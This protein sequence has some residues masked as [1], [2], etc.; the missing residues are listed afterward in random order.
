M[1]KIEFRRGVTVQRNTPF[2]ANVVTPRT[3]PFDAV[4][5]APRLPLFKQEFPEIDLRLV[6]NIWAETTNLDGVDVEV[7][8]GRVTWTDAQFEKLSDESIVPICAASERSKIKGTKDVAHGP[9]IPFPDSHY[10]MR[11]RSKLPIRAEVELFENWLRD[12]FS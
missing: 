3:K 4:R 11:R 10:L 1:Q 2:A 8:L 5:L 7:R 12:Q 6:S 9:L